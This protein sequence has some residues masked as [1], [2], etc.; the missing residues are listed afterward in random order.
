MDFEFATARRVLFGR[1]RAHQ[2]PELAR[3]WGQ[4]VLVV[5]GRSAAR[6]RPL[7][8][9]L[10]DAGLEPC[11]L[12]VQG[13]PTV[14][15]VLK[16]C[17]L[18]RE[19]RSE[20]VI[21][22]GGGSAIDAGK[23]IAA[24]VT[25]PGEA[26]DYLEVV[27]AGRPLIKPGL[28]FAAIPTTAGTGTEVTRNA[29]LASA[30]HRVKVSLRS[31]W[32]LAR[33]AVVDPELS[34]TL[35]PRLTA[36]TGLDALT[37]LIEPFV[38]CRANPLTDAVCREGL[39]RAGRSL[40]VAYNASQRLEQDPSA[41]LESTEQEAREDMAIA[42]CLSGMALANAGLG[43]VHGFAGPIGGMFPA[44]HGQV[45]AAL[46]PEVME[47]N[48]TAL[49]RRA[50]KH[51]ALTRYR[52]IGRLLCGV[53]EATAHD[54]LAW[55]RAL[56]LDLGIPRLTEHGI[57]QADVPVL[58]EKAQRASSMKGNPIPLTVEELAETLRE[59]I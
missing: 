2:V 18:A 11:L 35:P 41:T 51:P 33:L 6:V 52:E 58:V 48:L 21:A 34:Y 1:G 13:E 14:D 12:S 27:G 50:P 54:A 23:A 31:P 15:L 49:S 28:P 4:R 26:M 16:G 8:E 24:L 17:Q 44:P 5:S 39:A 32:L 20:C 38:S 47:Q 59:A 40:Q 19:Q 53:E 55:V 7:A 57:T 45:C 22:Q 3:S 42:A 25:N 36:A 10:V 46:L 30:E 9:S 37:Q 43:A 29:V 56:V